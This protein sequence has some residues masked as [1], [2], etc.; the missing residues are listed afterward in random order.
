VGSAF[1]IDSAYAVT[2]SDANTA[3]Q[4]VLA[5]V[6]ATLPARDSRDTAVINSVTN[7]N[8]SIISSTPAY[9]SLAAGTAPTDT[10]ADGMPDSWE[11]WYGTNDTVADNNGDL[12]G[13]GYTNLE[14][15]LQYRVDP[16][17]VTPG[18]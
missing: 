8:G 1:A 3:Y 10:D 18:N 13:D 16:N 5:G 9:P 4:A 14:R 12:N 15:Y 11:D 7:R 2:A 17:T 6:G